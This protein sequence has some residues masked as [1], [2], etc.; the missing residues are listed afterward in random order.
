MTKVVT[1]TPAF[2]NGSYRYF[3]QSPCDDEPFHL[4]EYIY[5]VHT[6]LFN[7]ERIVLILPRFPILGQTV[8]VYNNGITSKSLVL[9]CSDHN[10]YLIKPKN[11]CDLERYT[12]VPRIGI[13]LVL[14]KDNVGMHWKE[15]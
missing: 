4:N 9:E 14:S 5:M 12:L 7:V 1:L 3:L 15:I 13:E 11:T 10:E 8:A 2:F 6:D